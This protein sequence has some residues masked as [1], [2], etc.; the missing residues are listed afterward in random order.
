MEPLTVLAMV[1]AALAFV[2]KALPKI[3]EWTRNGEITAEQQTET[4]QRY[5]S[6]KQQLDAPGNRF[7]GE[8]W[9]PSDEQGASGAAP[10]PEVAS[11]TVREN[12]TS[13]KRNP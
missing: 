3:R 8:H 7:E 13:T 11:G 9:R 10:G 12:V 4:L 2:E 6:L 5:Q 1:N